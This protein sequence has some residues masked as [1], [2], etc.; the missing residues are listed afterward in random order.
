VRIQHRDASAATF[1]MEKDGEFLAHFSEEMGVKDNEWAF[2]INLEEMD[3]A[4][5]Y[6]A[7][8]FTKSK[9]LKPRLH[10]GHQGIDIIKL[11]D[12]VRKLLRL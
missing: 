6:M 5:F 1:D 8:A 9:I 12:I 11:P 2:L 3:T 7:F 4:R 10:L